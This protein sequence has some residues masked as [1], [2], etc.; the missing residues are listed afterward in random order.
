MTNGGAGGMLRAKRAKSNLVYDD[1]SIFKPEKSLFLKDPSQQH[2]IHCRFGM[3]GVIA[4]AH[5]DAPRNM[6]AEVAGTRRWFMAHPRECAHSYLL[7]IDHPS[8]R[9]TAVDWSKPDLE[10]Y[11]LFSDLQATEVLLTPGEVLYVPAFWIH[12]IVNLD[13]N[14]QCNT[15]SGNSKI[16]KADLKPCGFF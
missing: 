7:P 1:I 15:R 4:E 14:I 8:G 12:S 10:K 6:V 16:G 9:H 3:N 2:G 5:F 11:P 13:M